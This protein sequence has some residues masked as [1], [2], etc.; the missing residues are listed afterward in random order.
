MMALIVVLLCMLIWLVFYVFI[1]K[2]RNEQRKARQIELQRIS[3][4]MDRDGALYPK[5]VKELDALLDRL[6]KANDAISDELDRISENY[7]ILNKQPGSEEVHTLGYRGYVAAHDQYM[8][9]KYKHLREVEDE[10][11]RGRGIDRLQKR[12]DEIESEL[13]N[14]SENFRRRHGLD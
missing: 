3:A 12:A 5:L 10:M 13:A 1:E 8:R 6:N 11:R 14:W 2:P 4:A 9:E 7:D